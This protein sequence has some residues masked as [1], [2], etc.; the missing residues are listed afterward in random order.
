MKT[1]FAFF[2]SIFLFTFFSCRKED[3]KPDPVPEPTVYIVGNVEGNYFLWTDNVPESIDIDGQ[4]VYVDGDDV[5]IA[6][7]K[8]ENNY[9]KP[10]Y[11]KNGSITYLA[12]NGYAKSIFIDNNNVFV[13]GVSNNG[14][15]IWNNGIATQ[16]TNNASDVYDIF[17]KDNIVYA[18][19]NE[20]KSI[21][22][23]FQAKAWKNGV[24]INLGNNNAQ[25]DGTSVFVYNDDVYFTWINYDT[26]NSY[27]VKNG[28]QVFSEFGARFNSVFVENGD[29]YIAGKYWNGD[30]FEAAYW[31]NNSRIDLTTDGNKNAGAEDIFVKNGDVYVIGRQYVSNNDYDLI[32]WKNDIPTVVSPNAHVGVLSSIFVK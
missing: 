15:T 25:S 30:H 3:V 31:K 9:R 1:R 27:L 28:T 14:V 17:V 32:L 13:G 10:C 21:G 2:L 5:Y 4:S 7:T 19:G 18:I 16:F 11:T 8:W 29:V 20:Q 24:P 12:D 22:E 26:G 6:G 23:V